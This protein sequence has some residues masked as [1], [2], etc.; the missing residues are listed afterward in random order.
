MRSTSTDFFLMEGDPPSKREIL[1]CALHLFVRD[2]LC[3]TSI[4]DIAD[5]SGFTNPALYKFFESKE[6]LALHLFERC[7]LKLVSVIRASQ[8]GKDFAKDLDALVEAYARLVDEDLE[9]VLYVNDTLRLFW[10]KLPKSARQ[11]S[12]ISEIRALLERGVEARVVPDTIEKDLAVAVLVGAMGQIAR[13]AYFDE[14]DGPVSG[15]IA[16]IRNL[17]RRALMEKSR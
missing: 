10:R 2:G 17:F 11:H 6:A 5:A 9:A 12:L 15:Q 3:E 16:E 13:M 7:Y 1:R 4:R 14:I 8:K